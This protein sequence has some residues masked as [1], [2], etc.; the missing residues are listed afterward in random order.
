[1]SSNN[2][3]C[4]EAH[5]FSIGGIVPVAKRDIAESVGR[6]LLDGAD[7]KVP[8]G[9]VSD[10]TGSPYFPVYTRRWNKVRTGVARRADD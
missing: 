1:M 5:R 4:L 3:P 7:E 8:G 2:G 6:P 10:N 9:T